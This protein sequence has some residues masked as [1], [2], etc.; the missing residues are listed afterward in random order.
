ADRV[1]FLSGGVLIE[2]G[3]PEQ[4]FTAPRDPRTREFLARYL[5]S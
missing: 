3:T 5:P 2:E 1:V 4:I